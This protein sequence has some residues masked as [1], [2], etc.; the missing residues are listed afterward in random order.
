[1]ANRTVTP[2]MVTGSKMPKGKKPMVEIEVKRT[3]KLVAPKKAKGK[4]K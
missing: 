2:K 3:V 1:M 4:R